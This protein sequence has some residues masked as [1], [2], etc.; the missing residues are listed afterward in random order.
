[1]AQEETSPE[2]GHSRR[3]QAVQQAAQVTQP[4]VITDGESNNR[5]AGLVVRAEVELQAA[6]EYLRERVAMDQSV[7][8]AVAAVMPV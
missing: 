2:Q 7:V 8:E 4:T 6:A 1:M 3:Y 5:G